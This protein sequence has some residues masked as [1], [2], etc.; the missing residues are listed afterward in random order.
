MQEALEDE[1]F[2]NT[3]I[4]VINTSLS[5]TFNFLDDLTMKLESV[6]ANPAGMLQ[7]VE[8]AIESALGIGDDAFSLGLSNGNLD[9]NFN[10]KA[11]F[12]DKFDFNLDLNTFKE[13]SGNVG[14]AALDA[15]DS[16]ADL[17]GGGNLTLEA[18][19]ELNFDIGINLD[20]LLKGEAKI[21]LRDYDKSTGKGTHAQIGARV[22]GRELDLNFKAGP[23]NLGINN[24]TV[25]LDADGNLE[26]KDYAGLLVAIDQKAG[27][28]PDDG[29]F[30][31]GKES[32]GD[33]FQVKVNGGFDVNL[34]L[35]MELAGFDTNIGTFEV[36]TNP[37]Y[38]DQGLVQLFKHLAN[39]ADK[40]AE[41]PLV[42]K[43]P[44]IR[45]KFEELG[46]KFSLLGLINDPS[47][48]LDSVDIA[49]ETLEDVL[50]SN[51]AQDIP[52]VG[53]KLGDAASFLRDMR[54]GILSDLRKK[55]S[56]N[57]KAIEFIRETLYD[58]LGPNKLNIL[59]DTNKDNR[60][61]IEDVM[62]GWYDKL[63]N[64]MQNWSVGG[65]LPG[66]A[67]AIQFDMDLGQ[68]LL[69]TGFDLPLDFS[70]P[71]FS[72][73]VDGGFALDIGWKFDFGFGFCLQ[74]SFYL[75]TN[76]G[77]ELSLDIKAY[78]DGS[79]TDPAITPFKGEGNL[80]FLKAEIE[81]NNPDGR[82][83]G[84]YGGLSLDLKGDERGR[85]SIGKLLSGRAKD[86]FGVSFGVD[87]KLDLG[88][89][90]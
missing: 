83:S 30:Y 44:D 4:P 80:L 6:A 40:G 68:N 59:L 75:A 61:S 78:L 9:I 16:F 39:S 13:L 46:G 3:P 56:G 77:S 33:N 19:A 15:I 53:D 34:P 69:G 65:E 51:L 55:L 67:D 50:D 49:V 48:I 24:G 76:E 17:A 42:M 2:Y 84:I 10:W 72:L 37:V 38:G 26:T 12:S 90:L 54:L 31:I 70:I 62:V 45:K 47:F 82:A 25:V 7:E 23:I 89:T 73:D 57:G 60:I 52:L 28:T 32:F 43:Y 74:D 1:V 21:F 5:E 11:I 88:M 14:A 85:M 35:R 41:N 27:S 71:G 87:T 66:G 58:V 20:S 79:P 22:E 64:L 81:D 18:I 86:L 29:L 63:G 8:T 36:K